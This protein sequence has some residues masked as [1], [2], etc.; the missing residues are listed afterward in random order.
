MR[1]RTTCQVEAWKA[2]ARGHGAEK[3]TSMAAGLA[4]GLGAYARGAAAG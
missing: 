3:V 1:N 4:P 2:E